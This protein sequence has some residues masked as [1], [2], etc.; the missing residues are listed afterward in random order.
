MLAEDTFLYK[1]VISISPSLLRLL[2]SSCH[3]QVRHEA[4]LP[5]SQMIYAGWHSILPAFL[6]LGQD[7]KIAT[8]VSRSR[9]GEL[10][11]P[12]FKKLGF[13]VVRGS[14]HRGGIAAL[15]NLLKILKQ[16]YNVGLAVD[17]SRGP[18]RKVQGGILYLAMRSGYPVVAVGIAYKNSLKLST[19]DRMEVPLPFTKM[20]VVYG[21]PLYLPKKLTD[22]EFE[23][24][25]L[26]LEKYLFYLNSKARRLV[27]HS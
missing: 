26:H 19:W 12:V 1:T 18:A 9:D 20:G 23:K 5:K 15:K 24:A 10:I 22:E 14:R 27:T 6:Y 21:E 13:E 4:P 8:M 7:Q 2:F 17:G 3:I 25:R 11:T 16:G